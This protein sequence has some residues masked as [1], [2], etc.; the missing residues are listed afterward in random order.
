VARTRRSAQRTAGP[1]R[2][3][4]VHSWFTKGSEAHDLLLSISF[5][6]QAPRALR[7]ISSPASPCRRP[8]CCLRY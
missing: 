8:G 4:A 6:D 3:R 2:R 7:Q 1:R 5:N